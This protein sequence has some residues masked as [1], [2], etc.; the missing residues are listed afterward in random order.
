LGDED[1]RVSIVRRRLLSG[2]SW[3]L[4]D[5][6]LSALSNTVLSIVVA[7]SATASDFG[8]FAIAFI[9]F[10]ISIALTKSLVGQPLQ[11]RFSGA[12]VR[13]QSGAI[14][15]GL[16]AA[17]VIGVV[18]AAVVAGASLLTPNE[19]GGALL[20][21]A[22]V[23]PA[24]LLQDSCRMALFAI[25]RPRA[26]AVLDAVWTAIML[27]LLVLLVAVDRNR[28]EWLIIAW[29]VGAFGSALLGLR[30]LR[31]LPAAPKAV[32]WLSA[33]WDLARY[34]FGEYFLGLGAMHLGILL[35]ALIATADAV[36]AL[37]AAQVL[38]GPLGIV[39][40]GA[41]QFA[42][43]EIARRGR[44][45]ERTLIHIALGL[46]SALGFMTV[47]YVIALLLLPDSWGTALFG[48]SWAG[49]STVLLAMGASSLF[50]SLA[51][52]PACV[53]YGSGQA[54][55]TFRINLAKGPVLLIAVMLGTWSAA[56]VGAGWAFALTEA[57]VLPAWILTMRRAVRS[58]PDM[59]LAGVDNE[60][61]PLGSRPSMR[62]KERTST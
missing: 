11:I 39:A 13:A 26:A 12:D 15:Q 3:N 25:G 9:V 24:L 2:V 38:L 30:L 60:E 58:R 35:V 36:G 17:L 49:A 23:L 33:Q 50:S 59:E 28:V 6:A 61:P 29:G 62:A 8:A 32:R 48:D 51:N 5:Q 14:R 40:A 53:L 54:R 22:V 56:A 47:V 37:R 19:V 52:G 18:A 27:A 7:R 16:G 57:A 41:F 43:P 34:L 1:H 44:L 31:S 46:S 42:M 45:G 4:I 21:L 10:G 20:A 55:S